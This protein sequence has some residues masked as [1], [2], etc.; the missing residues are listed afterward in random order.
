M[1]LQEGS[2]EDLG[3]GAPDAARTAGSSRSASS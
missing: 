1:M 2:R 3:H